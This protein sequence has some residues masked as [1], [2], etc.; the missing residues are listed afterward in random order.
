MICWYSSNAECILKIVDQ[1]MFW[2]KASEELTKISVILD[3]EKYT[4]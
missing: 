3:V 2:S 4:H 1:S